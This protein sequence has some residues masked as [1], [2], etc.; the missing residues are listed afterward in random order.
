[1]VMRFDDARHWVYVYRARFVG[2]APPIEFRICIKFKPEASKILDDVPNFAT[3]PGGLMMKLL[4]ARIL[5][6]FGAP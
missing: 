3:Y 6:L 1:M 4:R 5:M 2:D